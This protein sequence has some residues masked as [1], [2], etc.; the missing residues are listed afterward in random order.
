M[1]EIIKENQIRNFLDVLVKRGDI[2]NSEFLPK[3][4]EIVENVKKN[5]D[6]ALFEY[7]ALFDSPVIN[8]NNFIISREKMERG[9]WSLDPKMRETLELA[10]TRITAY[11]EKE[12]NNSW[13]EYKANGEILGNK[14]SPLKRVG[15]YVPGGK[16][17]YPST[18]LMNTIPAQIAGVEEIIMVTPSKSLE[19]SNIILAAAYLGGVKEIYLIGGAQSIAALAYGT[20]LIKRV[21]KIVG[22]GNIYV[23]LAKKEVY[24]V[25][26]IDSIAG[27][28]EILIVADEGANPKYLAADL[29]SQAEH[30]ELASAIL[31]TN[32]EELAIKTRSFVN[33]YYNQLSR[34]DIMSKSLNSFCKII[35]I[36]NLNNAFKLVNEIAPEHL[37]LQLKDA[38]QFVA[39]VD[40]AGAI[41]L[42]Y[43]TP[44][45]LGDYMAGSNHVL[46]T[47][48]TSR[49]FSPLGVMDFMKKSSII[50]FSK[51]ALQEL[52]T[53]VVGFAKAEGLD[54]HALSVEVR[55]D[56]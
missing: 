39:K 35:L 45:A 21:D 31:I 48:Q 52:G 17:S 36:D 29:L 28:S 44:E 1:I 50:Y 10:K 55:L 30:D 19:L 40:N 34:K 8:E 33:N 41:F 16:A 3:V 27:P 12:K 42:G 4:K 46:P 13:I 9:Y 2:T 51:E 6:K 26:S 49:F 24:G 22:P 25:V 47:N 14:V 38:M 43:F 20:K 15:I 53:K 5:G 37:E 32:S 18:V 56:E 7:T 23:A 54:A 11:H